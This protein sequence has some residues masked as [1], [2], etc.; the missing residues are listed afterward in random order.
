MDE[1]ISSN[2]PV[3]EVM[4]CTGKFLPKQAVGLIDGH[5]RTLDTGEQLTRGKTLR[6]TVCSDD[7]LAKRGWIRTT[8]V[9]RSLAKGKR[10][11]CWR[12]FA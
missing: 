8:G 11:E 6:T 9:A 1:M 12:N 7:W 3:I 4:H 5:K 2:D 10:R